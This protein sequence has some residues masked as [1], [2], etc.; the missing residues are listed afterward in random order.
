MFTKKNNAAVWL[1]D[2]LNVGL[3]FT[4]CVATMRAFR[5]TQRRFP[6]DTAA[7]TQMPLQSGTSSSK[8]VFATGGMLVYQQYCVETVYRTWLL[9]TSTD[10]HSCHRYRDDIP[11]VFDPQ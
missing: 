10:C 8:L 9:C 4:T 1:R 2:K 7:T 5:V 6:R 3:A 11:M